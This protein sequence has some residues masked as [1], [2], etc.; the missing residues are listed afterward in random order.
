MIKPHESIKAEDFEKFS[1]S[2]EL[3]NFKTLYALRQVE[4][5]KKIIKF[6]VLHI[7]ELVALCGLVIY[8]IFR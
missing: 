6:N 4:L 3:I 7:I 8:N 2:N 1:T 5:D